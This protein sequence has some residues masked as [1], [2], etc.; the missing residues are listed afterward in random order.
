MVKRL[1]TSFFNNLRCVS[2]SNEFISFLENNCI[3]YPIGKAACAPVKPPK[4]TIKSGLYL[5]Y[6]I[7]RKTFISSVIHLL[8]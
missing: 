6:K 8:I 7:I 1:D 3:E 2:L 5:V 4:Q